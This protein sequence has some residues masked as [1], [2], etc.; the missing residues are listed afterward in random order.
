MHRT[1]T[2]C[3]GAGSIERPL[4]TH[5]LASGALYTGPCRACGGEGLSLD[6][7][8]TLGAVL[9]TAYEQARRAPSPALRE[10]W[11]DLAAAT[12]A[13]GQA[14]GAC[15]AT[16]AAVDH[17]VHA[18][19]QVRREVGELAPR[20]PDEAGRG[21]LWNAGLHMAARAIARLTAGVSPV[22]AVPTARPE[23]SA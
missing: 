16:P 13:L 8:G 15:L 14:A 18:V 19:M 12:V 10:A 1:C 23:G 7:G 17:P 5:G 6:L 9:S 4:S 22:S 11:T 2:H 21:Q 3:R 20:E